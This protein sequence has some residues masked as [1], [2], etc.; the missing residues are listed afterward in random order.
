MVRFV[1]L[2][3]ESI[4]IYVAM[5]IYNRCINFRYLFKG[6]LKYKTICVSICCKLSIPI[7]IYNSMYNTY[8][9][10]HHINISSYIYVY[11]IRQRVACKK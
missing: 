4:Y 3:P 5:S 2:Q 1:V 9:R 7:Y 10:I 6:T 8:Y 11:E